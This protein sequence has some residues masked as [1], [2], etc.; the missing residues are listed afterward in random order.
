M[1]F[2][3]TNEI[4]YLVL[5]LEEMHNFPE[6]LR[7]IIEKLNH[8]ARRHDG[9]LLIRGNLALF[10][11]SGKDEYIKNHIIEAII[12][13]TGDFQYNKF[14]EYL[15]Q[16]IVVSRELE[17]SINFCHIISGTHNIKLNIEENFDPHNVND[18]YKFGRTN[19]DA[20]FYDPNSRSLE[21]PSRVSLDDNVVK[22]LSDTWDI[23]SVI[24]IIEHVG[25][26][27]TTEVDPDDLNRL[28]TMPLSGL[29]DTAD[30]SWNEKIE[31]I[32]LLPWSGK[33]LKFM[34]ETFP[35]GQAW[36]FQSLVDYMISLNVDIS[37]EADVYSVF[38]EKKFKIMDL[39]NEF[40]LSE[41]K[42][43]E[44]PK[45]IQYRLNTLVKLLFDSPDLNIVRP[46][47]NQI[48]IM[49]GGVLGRC[50]IGWNS[51]GQSGPGGD[52]FDR[53]NCGNG[54][55]ASDCLNS[56]FLCETGN[57]I[58]QNPSFAHIPDHEWEG[59]AQFPLTIPN[60]RE[61]CADQICPP[62]RSHVHCTPTADNPTGNKVPQCLHFDIQNT[63]CDCEG[64]VPPNSSYCPDGECL[65][66]T[67][68]ECV[69]PQCC[70]CHS[71]DIVLGVRSRCYDKIYFS[72]NRDGNAPEEGAPVF[73]PSCPQCFE[74]CTK[75]L[76]GDGG[77]LSISGAGGTTA[78]DWWR[79]GPDIGPCSCDCKQFVNPSNPAEGCNLTCVTCEGLKCNAEVDVQASACSYQINLTPSDG[80]CGIPARVD[81]VFCIDYSD[82]MVDEIQDVIDN[83]SDLASGLITTGAAARFGLV[84]YGQTENS[85]TPTVVFE[86]SSDLTA[87]TNAVNRAANGG[88]EPAFDAVEL[89]LQHFPWDGVENLLFLI[90]DEP[91]H[92]PPHGGDKPIGGELGDPNLQPPGSLL[93]EIAN[94]FGVRVIDIQPQPGNV[95]VGIYDEKKEL[96]ALA[97]G[98]SEHD[99][100]ST[101][102]DIIADLN[103]NVFASSCNC[104]DI[105]PVPVEICAGVD[106]KGE[107][108]SGT[109]DIPIRKCVAEDNSDCQCN[110]PRT[111]NIC[112]EIVVLTPEPSTLN[113]ICCGDI[114]GGG[115]ECPTE[116]APT[117]CCGVCGQDI[118]PPAY[119]SLQEAIDSIWCECWFKAKAGEF[120]FE[121]TG[122]DLRCTVPN[123]DD[124]DFNDIDVGAILDCVIK[125]PDGSGGFT[126]VS[127]SDVEREVTAAWA[128]CEGGGDDEV[129]PSIEADQCLPKCDI[130]D[131]CINDSNDCDINSECTSFKN[132]A[133][134]I[135]NN[136]V[137][138]VAYEAFDNNS[139]IKIQ[140][141]HTSVPGKILPHRT[142]N[143]GRLQNQLQWTGDPKIAKLYFYDE[144][145]PSHFVSGIDHTRTNADIVD[146]LVF[147]SG[148]LQNQ[149]FPLFQSS[150]EPIEGPIGE[151]SIGQYI[152]F[153][154]GDAQLSQSFPTSDDIYNIEWFIVDIQDPGL[155]GSAFDTGNT[156]G[157]EFILDE[158]DIN[159][160]LELPP[161][162]H[163]GEQVP[164]ANPSITSAKNYMNHLENSHF[165]YLVYQALEDK[166]WNLYLK[167]IRLSEYSREEQLKADN[168]VFLPLS[169]PSLNLNE[170]V[171][172]IVCVN[173]DCIPSFDDFIATRSI[174][175]EVLLPDG[176]EVFNNGLSDDEFW[177]NLCPG[178]P[179]GEFPKNRAFVTFT[180]S[181]LADKC[182]DQFE[183]ND[184]FYNWEVGDEF[185]IP[186]INLE[187]TDLF[188]LLRKADDTAIELNQTDITVG[189]VIISSSG[190]SSAQYDAFAGWITIDTTSFDELLQFK[191]LDISEPIP[192]TEFENGH[193]THPTVKVNRNN[194]VFVAYECTDPHLH[195]I[196][197]TGTATPSSSL[198]LGVFSPKNIDMNLDYFFQPKDFVFR[199]AVTDFEDAVNQLPDMHIDVND[200]VHLTW[201]S[202]RDNVWEIYY[203]VSEN[204]FTNKR[205]TDFDSKSLNPTI[206]CDN[207]GNIHIVWQDNRFG[208]WEILMAYQDNVRIM[209]LFEQDP[210]LASVR[211]EGW[212]HNLDIVPLSLNNVSTFSVLCISE[213]IVRFYEFRTFE[214]LAFSISQG[215]W[216]F[217]F[218]LPVQD[219]RSTFTFAPPAF[220]S[221][222]ITTTQ[223]IDRIKYDIW[224]G[225]IFDSSIVGSD[226]EEFT[227]EFSAINFAFVKF[228]AGETSDPVVELADAKQQAID[229]GLN[230]DNAKISWSDTEWINIAH[231]TS[232]TVTNVADLVATF[233]LFSSSLVNGRYKRATFAVAL[234]DDISGFTLFSITSVKRGRLCIA[235]GATVKGTLD[236]TPTIRVDKTG[237]EVVETPIPAGIEPNKTYFALPLA[238]KDD[239]NI[240]VFQDTKKSVS[241]ASCNSEITPWDFSSCSISVDLVNNANKK[242]F[243]NARFR[244]HT[245]IEMTNII[246]QFDAFIDG[247]LECLTVED[248][249]AAQDKWVTAGYEIPTNSIRKLTLWPM[250][251]NTVGL[252]CG[253]D[254][255]VLIE[256][257]SGDS[258]TPCV[259]TSLEFDSLNKWICNCNSP[260]WDGFENA[261]TNIR[262]LVRWISSGDGFSDTRMTETLTADNFNPTIQIRSDLT[263][264]IIYESNRNDLDRITSGNNVHSIFASAF[265]V[266]P[267]ANMYATGAEAITSF[268]EMLI[269]SDIPVWA[270]DA[271]GCDTPGDAMEGRNASFSLDQYDNVFLAFEKPLDQ[272]ECQEFEENKHT[273]IVVHRCGLPIDKLAFTKEAIDPGNDPPPEEHVILDRVAPISTDSIFKS[274]IRQVRVQNN[275]VRYHII[276][277]SKPAAV[278]D[279]CL[280]GLEIVIEPDVI[281]IRIRT[282]KSDW[283][284][285]MPASPKIGEHTVIVPWELSPGSG[286]KVVSVEAA[287]YQGVT[288]SFSTTIIAD[289]KLVDH[290]VNFYKSNNP[291]DDV[292]EPTKQQLQG[293][294]LPSVNDD[295][296]VESNL[297]SKL[298]G[299]PVAGIRSPILDNDDITVVNK[300]AEFI[301]VEFFVSQEYIDT[302]DG[303]LI[304]NAPTFDVIQQGGND[305]FDLP[306]EYF[307]VNKTFRGIFPISKDNDGLHKDG[308][309]FIIP[310][311]Q[312]DCSDAATDT[313]ESGKSYSRDVF[314]SLAQGKAFQQGDVPEDI[315]ASERDS[316]GAIKHKIDIR[317]TEDPYFV[318]GDPNYRLKKDKG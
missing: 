61:W 64:G 113:L 219:D 129:P 21:Y 104:L 208:N 196:H 246:A 44:K 239:G 244:F 9:R 168:A 285:W 89:A 255:W 290:T 260:R 144:E 14:Y 60:L 48:G 177:E 74:A 257:C 83:V 55:D 146:M 226:F 254:Y 155:T 207:R 135:L 115:C 79:F 134:T 181:A 199:K 184:I 315:F 57:C 149:C 161:H 281:A 212:V 15:T 185:F 159:S 274:I 147:R 192:I 229:N 117:G 98:G 96:L 313:A 269:R 29:D 193:C 296:F 132:P 300:I 136:G 209:P 294:N 279:Q 42:W 258:D 66:C 295:I 247:E 162:I 101:F 195:Q 110:D 253:I 305:L 216:P 230:P 190:V 169:D 298:D 20:I 153:V 304:A 264:I 240:H 194:D 174:T 241:C 201:Q 59:F 77:C 265:S 41:K 116:D 103:L 170:L 36:T 32:L 297:L 95:D 299:V 276:R 283:S 301:F 84:T 250:L 94:L 43:E 27:S 37:E 176:R 24:S 156:P 51:I 142:T 105:N 235:P 237:D 228:S 164:V 316:T 252:L 93:A 69:G 203:A 178:V 245:D 75:A 189:S 150:T 8:C 100:A 186:F 91:V 278:V 22:T 88:N 45:E 122:C 222:D 148:P 272:K 157:A 256:T 187:A 128:N 86:L 182:P 10:A 17:S 141:F 261:P 130:A 99:L 118:C 140:Q 39:Y 171:Y 263:G 215:E 292:P 120:F 266:F 63:G 25:R 293:N 309:S 7:N 284:T 85:G 131:E 121:T 167:Q 90:G 107:C 109:T 280:I 49:A 310:H 6:Q 202:N 145:V 53:W 225:D 119:D 317:T 223:I 19:L 158:A 1:L 234:G 126:P 133:T 204:D 273:N 220:S 175:M 191:G 268:G 30:F 139:I 72:C 143:F 200:V 232:G 151:D 306:T 40:F 277:N 97:T 3:T 92:D 262:D 67:P 34:V 78:P 11:M 82:S 236:L 47:I 233:A 4:A 238:V 217:A 50:C 65:T 81:A 205:I 231:I 152:Q 303:E 166:K 125:I 138:L 243:F 102:S 16:R 197:V 160:A 180:H 58:Q 242:K 172:R 211:N 214:K 108:V 80:C 5:G 291:E 68:S 287:T 271:S 137:G 46:Y 282:N 275:F 23:N 173:D 188:T 270:C 198:P 62:D 249:Q 38:N 251:S 52:H 2:H 224:I 35:D 13:H 70:C 106:S 124:P 56:E 267:K 54:I 33:S 221:W 318:F 286:L 218:D 123:P 206:N 259:R 307:P 154:V 183:F 210:Y 289:Y 312:N 311:F 163:D 18:V 73:D 248:N 314:N 71:I 12:S 114:E 179:V 28:K 87:F 76:G 112:G 213:I 26:T 227:L 165:V 302:L 127:R 288:G 111:F 308:L 31:S